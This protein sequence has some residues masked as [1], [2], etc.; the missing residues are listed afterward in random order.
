MTPFRSIAVFYHVARTQSVVA[1]AEHLHVTSSAVSQQ[2]RSLE[3][4]IGTTLVVRSGRTVRLTEAGERYFEL[5][6]EDIEHIIKVTDQIKGIQTPTRLTIRATPTIATKWLLPRLDDFLAAFPGLEIRLDGS[7]EPTDF[8][9]DRVDIEIRHGT[10]RWP[11]LHSQ[12]LVT[13]TF[14][15]V[16]SP[17]IAA[18]AS[19]SPE[20]ITQQRLIHSVKAQVQWRNW[21]NQ[22][23]IKDE[24]FSG[25]LYFDRS[26]MSVDAAV[27]GLGIA[28]ESN[29]MMSDEIRHG[30]LILPAT[31]NPIMQLCTQWLVC[32]TSSLRLP[33]VRHF[34]EWVEEAAIRWHEESNELFS[35]T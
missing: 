19:L 30:E 10:G 17:K 2:L 20:E 5:I 4:Q 32:P 35:Q 16:C 7:N 28:L 13:E 15:A 23:G 33:H 6:S 24:V 27:L 11:G 31:E 34:I 21:F 18:P 3:E 26:H 8:S 14:F 9:R 29:L 25:S 22:Q 1:A 12:P